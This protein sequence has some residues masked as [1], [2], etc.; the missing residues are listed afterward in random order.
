MRTMALM[1][2]SEFPRLLKL[3][4]EIRDT[5]WEL[6]LQPR[7]IFTL[8][9]MTNLSLDDIAEFDEFGEGLGD[10]SAGSESKQIKL[11]DEYIAAL[12]EYFENHVPSSC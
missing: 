9:N 4:R 1:N 5:I 3:P 6:V 12:D 11:H 10:M 7:V 8:P 2:N